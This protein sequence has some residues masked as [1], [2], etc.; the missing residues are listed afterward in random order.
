M[1]KETVTENGTQGLIE[2]L[3][4]IG[5]LV[6]NYQDVV[7]EIERGSGNHH[8]KAAAQSLREELGGVTR[9][10]DRHIDEKGR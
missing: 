1:P 10:I 3:Q 4:D 9:S 8:I 7:S 6:R 5:E 2:A